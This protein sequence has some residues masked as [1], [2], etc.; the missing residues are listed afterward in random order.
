[1]LQPEQFHY[2][3]GCSS[4]IEPNFAFEYNRKTWVNGEENTFKQ[5][6]PLYS[7]YKDSV[8]I[9]NYFVT[10]MDI[11]PENHIK[12]QAIFQKNCDSG[13][14]KT[15]NIPNDATKDN[16]GDLIF[17]GMEYGV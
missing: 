3:Q 14:S 11:S 7:D 6:H 9:P 15:V 8:D 13:I 5:Y 12:M 4:G 2:S 1:M 17:H 10:T 16:V